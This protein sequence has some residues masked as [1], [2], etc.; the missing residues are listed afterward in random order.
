MWGFEFYCFEHQEA[1][2]GTAVVT[3]L[4]ALVEGDVIEEK[5]FVEYYEGDSHNKV[6]LQMLVSQLR[7]IVS[8]KH[9]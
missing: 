3:A 9:V 8:Q 1:T 2:S 7:S 4:K 5:D 6:W